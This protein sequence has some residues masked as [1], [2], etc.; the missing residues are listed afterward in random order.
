[1]DYALYSMKG[2]KLAQKEADTIILDF[3]TSMKNWQQKYLDLGARDT[4]SREA[5]AI[6]TAECLGLKIFPDENDMSMN[7]LTRVV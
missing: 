6:N 3:I 7:M 1:M 4:M 2:K 5:F